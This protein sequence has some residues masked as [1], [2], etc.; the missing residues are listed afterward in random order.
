MWPL[1]RNL[2]HFVRRVIS[3]D[4]GLIYVGCSFQLEAFAIHLVKAAA[5]WDCGRIRSR[6]IEV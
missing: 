3:M 4:S 2:Q 5:R 1:F 6:D